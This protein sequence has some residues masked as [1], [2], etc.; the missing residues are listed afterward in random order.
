MVLYQAIFFYC[1]F[2]FFVRRLCTIDFPA[3]E[4]IICPPLIDAP[5]PIVP[6]SFYSYSVFASRETVAVNFSCLFFR[7]FSQRF[8]SCSESTITIVFYC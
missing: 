6:V 3:P 8:S 7:Y 1:S 4:L 5:F 2:V